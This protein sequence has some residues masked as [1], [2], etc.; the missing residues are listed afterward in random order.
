MVDRK[1]DAYIFQSYKKIWLWVT[2]LSVGHWTRPMHYMHHD[3]MLWFWLS[4]S[5]STIFEYLRHFFGKQLNS[6]TLTFTSSMTRYNS[7]GM[8]ISSIRSTILGCLTR[9]KMDTSFWIMCSCHAKEIFSDYRLGGKPF[10]SMYSG[11]S[12]EDWDLCGFFRVFL[13][14][15]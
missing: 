5:T 6:K 14:R 7:V 2:H 9:L 12:K 10:T 8:S 13:K 15:L 11:K 3:T 1:V 4:F